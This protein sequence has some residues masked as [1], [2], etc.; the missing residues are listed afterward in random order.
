[1]LFS[2]ATVG[3]SKF[4]QSQNGANAQTE[5]EGCINLLAT[6]KSRGLL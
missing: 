1:M 6:E 4:G 5:P 3:E 2:A